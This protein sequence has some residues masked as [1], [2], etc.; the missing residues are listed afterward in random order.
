MK[1][2][3]NNFV[4]N[5]DKYTVAK[6]KKY[7]Y[8]QAFHIETFTFEPIYYDAV[9]KANF[10]T[11]STKNFVKAVFNDK[12]DKKKKGIDAHLTDDLKPKLKCNAPCYTCLDSDP[13]WCQSC[14]GKG[15]LGGSKYKEYFLQATP[16]SSTCKKKCDNGYTTD[17]DIVIP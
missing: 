8:D 11:P 15:A 16:S 7:L 2:P 1:N 6:R 4:E 10:D 14:W 5:T 17:G 9:I 3:T 13:N 12:P